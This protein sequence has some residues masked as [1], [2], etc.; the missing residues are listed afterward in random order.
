MSEESV[1]DAAW[2]VNLGEIQLPDS[3]EAKHRAVLA[4]YLMDADPVLLDGAAAEVDRHRRIDQALCLALR[5]T[6]QQYG[7]DYAL[8]YVTERLETCADALFPKPPRPPRA[9]PGSSV[10]HRKR[11]QVFKRDNYRCVVC[12]AEEDLTID[13]IDPVSQG[14]RPTLDNLRTLCRSCN[15]RKGPRQ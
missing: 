7:A 2:A 14:G 13:H 12:G 15:S 11:W 10:T 3:L 9:Y 5:L 4:R 6:A 8:T 1:W